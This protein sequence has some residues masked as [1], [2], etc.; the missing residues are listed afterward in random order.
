MAESPLAPVPRGEGSGVRGLQTATKPVTPFPGSQVPGSQAPLGNPRREALLRV[1]IPRDR[2][3]ADAKRS[4]ATCVPKRSLGTSVC[5]GFE[6]FPRKRQATSVA[7]FFLTQVPL[8]S[9]PSV[10]QFRSCQKEAKA[11]LTAGL[12]RWF[13]RRVGRSRPAKLRK[14]RLRLSRVLVEVPGQRRVKHL[15]LSGD[16]LAGPRR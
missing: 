4:F 10:V 16:L 3:L 11:K 9:V 14:Q 6:G 15:D 8:V 5:E 7:L 12:P 2:R 1:S 13:R